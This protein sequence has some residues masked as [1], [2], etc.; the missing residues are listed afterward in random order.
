MIG[1]IT[2]GTSPAG[3]L[4]YAMEKEGGELLD[5]NCVSNDAN[6]IASE[7]DVVAASNTRCE[8]HCIHITLSAPPGEKLTDEQWRQAAEVTRRELGLEQNQY[9]LVRHTD[10]GHDHAHLIVERVNPEGK[11]WSDKFERSR[12]HS[13]MRVVEKEVGLQKFSE[14]T[15]TKDG[16][17]E[18]TKADFKDSIKGAGSRGL[19]GFKSE[20][21]R[22]GYDV[23]EN[24]QTTGRLAGLSVKSREDGKTWKASELQRGGA[25]AVE[26]QL[27]RQTKSEQKGKVAEGASISKSAG[28]TASKG[29]DKAIGKN[30][31]SSIGKNPISRLGR[32][33]IS[34]VTGNS[35]VSG[36]IGKLG[37]ALIKGTSKSRSKGR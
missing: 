14:H 30:P 37:G 27:D 4:K 8:K 18:R 26:A 5:T 3:A 6:G 17:F 2:K 20:M 28:N 31:I 19:D 9:A 13:A 12:I 29:V 7:M 24:R 25:W 10:K 35:P 1:K 33:P 23:I 36:I 34:N 11:A 32:S 15:P 22:R 16:R 21:D